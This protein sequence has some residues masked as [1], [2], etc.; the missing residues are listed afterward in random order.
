MN[1]SKKHAQIVMKSYDYSQMFDSM[2]LSIT[3]SDLFDC[4]I[5]DDLLVLLNEVNK[6]ITMSVNTHAMV[7]QSQLFFPP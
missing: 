7:S 6:D 3:I 4:G 2:S 5:Q 1:S